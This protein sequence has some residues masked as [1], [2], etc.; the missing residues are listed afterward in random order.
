[1]NNRNNNTKNN[2]CGDNNK[3]KQWLKKVN[4]KINK[5]KYVTHS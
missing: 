2:P 5:Y 4:K 1:M 3:N